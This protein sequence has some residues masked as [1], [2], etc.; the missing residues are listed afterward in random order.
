MVFTISGD[1]TG[2]TPTCDYC[3]IKDD[4][5]HLCTT[6]TRVKKIWKYF[7]PTYEKPTKQQYI[8]Q[9][10]IFTLRANNLNPKD[11]KLIP[12]L[13]QLIMYEIWTSRNN[14]KYDKIQLSHET[15]ITKILTQLRNII[16]VH[17]KLHKRNVTHIP[18]TI[19]HK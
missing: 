15:I 2:L 7:Q 16:T 9:Q 8:P 13:T 6:C 1:K 11:K 14:I 18:A 5:I 10:H 3:N 19:L 17:Y 4:N 12:T